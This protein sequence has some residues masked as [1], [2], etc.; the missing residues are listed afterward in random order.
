MIRPLPRKVRLAGIVLLLAG[1]AASAWYWQ[2]QQAQPAQS[3]TLAGSIEARQVRPGFLVSG[4]IKVLHV[5]EGM[6]VKQGQLLAELD[7]RDY[8]LALQQVTAQRDAAA[9]T[10]AALEA[11]S[12]PEEIRAAEAALAETEARLDFAGI[13]LK[14]LQKLVAKKLASP[15]QLDRA[16]TERKATRAARDRARQNLRLLRAGPRQEDIDRARAQLAA[17]EAALAIAR[18]RLDYTRL[19]TPVAGIV[20]VRLAEAGNVVAS[21]VPVF[22]IDD[23]QHPWVRAWLNERDL[24]RVTLGQPVTILTDGLSGQGFQGTL[25]YISPR[26]E[27]TPKTVET[28]ALRVDLVY[29]IKVDV[30]NPDGQL[31]LGMPVDL[32]LSTR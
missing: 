23:L 8:R 1:A 11:G 4:R 2:R 6:F 32:I 7:D 22:E 25:A 5:D 27:F 3:L 17:A 15:E 16:R 18:Q 20:S 10:L 14:R 31:K 29:R 13:E 19:R 30:A 12:R 26:A 24:P 21:G 9:A 28:R